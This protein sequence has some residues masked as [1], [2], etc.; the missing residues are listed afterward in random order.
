[1]SWLVGRK[2]DKYEI[3]ILFGKGTQ[4]TNI[5]CVGEVEAFLRTGSKGSN[6]SDQFE[7]VE[8]WHWCLWQEAIK[9][10]VWGLPSKP[11][12]LVNGQRLPQ[13]P[14]KFQRAS[15]TVSNTEDAEM[16]MRE[17]RQAIVQRLGTMARPE[18]LPNPGVTRTPKYSFDPPSSRKNS[19]YRRPNL[20]AR[21]STLHGFQNTKRVHMAYI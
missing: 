20:A 10:G 1:M 9:E 17:Q 18:V 4:E 16:P 12:Y 14:T 5:L 6:R 3:I 8:E 19:V 15:A 11:M 13:L 21:Q 2:K 7:S